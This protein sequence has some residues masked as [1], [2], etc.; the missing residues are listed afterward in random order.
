MPW[1]MSDP[2]ACCI[3]VPS[4]RA[5]S[6][7]AGSGISSVMT[8]QGVTAAADATFVPGVNRDV[9]RC[10]SPRWARDD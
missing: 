3:A 10:R 8:I 6:D 1:I 7:A 9:R 2:V 5:V 4:G